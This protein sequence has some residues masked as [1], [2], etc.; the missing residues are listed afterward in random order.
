MGMTVNDVITQNVIAMLEDG[1]APWRK[2]WTAGSRPRNIVSN[3]PYTGIN[4]FLT[5]AQGFESPFW[6]TFKQMKT[7]GG[8]LKDGAKSTAV[9][10]YTT[11]EKED[12]ETGKIKKSFILR[13]YKVFNLEQTEGVRVP[14]G[15][16]TET[17][18]D[19][20]PIEAAEAIW[21]GYADG[22]S[23]GFG[24]DS[25][26]YV[27]A[28]DAI[29]LPPR[30]SF[31]GSPEYYSTLFHEAGHSTGHADRLNRWDDSH[32]HRFGCSDYGREELIAEMTAA[33]LAGEAGIAQ[34]T[35]PNSAAYLAS[36][37]R[38]LKGE[39]Q[40]IVKAAAAA[41]KAADRILGRSATEAAPATAEAA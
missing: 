9:I 25:A 22:P 11:T 28:L 13:F 20:D 32:D 19:V 1:T 4:V 7:L 3:R 5:A 41:Q 39:P 38:T 21:S 30:S 27:P 18:V 35:L 8:Q 40:L 14:K 34:D 31:T 33:F 12:R 2:P 17:P 26:H 36:W 37:I 10:F 24:G 6:M 29:T 23:L 16:V 15:R